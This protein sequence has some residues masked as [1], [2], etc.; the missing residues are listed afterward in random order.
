V[1]VSTRV[2]ITRAAERELR[3]FDAEDAAVTTLRRR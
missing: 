3:F 1:A 2:G